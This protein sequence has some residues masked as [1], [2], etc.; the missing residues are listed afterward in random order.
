MLTRLPDPF[1]TLLKPRRI[2]RLVGLCA[3]FA[4]ALSCALCTTAIGQDS[5]DDEVPKLEL[6]DLE[7]DGL[8][9]TARVIISSV[10]DSNP[11]TANDLVRAIS[12]ML[13][14][15]MYNDAKFY[16]ERIN[17]LNLN[18]D[19]MFAL[20]DTVGSDFFFLI[21][22]TPGVQPEGKAFAK[23]VLTTAR[24]ISTTPAKLDPLIQ[25]LNDADVSTRSAAFRKL[26]LLG[27]PAVARM[28][29][30]FSKPANKPLFPGIR[31]AFQHIGA[32]NQGPLLGGAR[33]ANLQV[34]VE[35][36]RALSHL[37]S[38]EAYDVM[39][40]AYLSPK[41]PQSTRRL[42]LDYLSRAKAADPRFIE[43]RLYDR[44]LEYM[45][46]KRE[47][48][49]ALLGEVIM[50][51]WDNAAGRMLP[52]KVDGATASRVIGSRRANDLF[53]INPDSEENRELYYLSQL[54]A[55]KRLAKSNRSVDVKELTG[56]LGLNSGQ[57]ETLLERSLELELIPAAIA[58]CEILKET[59]D[60]SLL[61]GT[62]SNPRPLVQAI[63]FG[64]RHLQFAAFDAISNIDPKQAYAGSSY[65]VSLAVFMAQS[66]NRGAGLIGHNLTSTAQTYAANMSNAGLFG[67]S[68][69]NS[70]DFFAEA[71]DNPDIEV[72]IVTDTMGRPDYAD[73]I[74][75]LRNDWRTKRV[76]I[77][78]LY[79]DPMR[80]R[81][82]TLRVG[83]DP[84][85]L[86][87]PFATDADHVS[88]HI[89]QLRQKL[90]P[91]QISSFE[92]RK[93]AAAGIRWL[94]K[95]AGDRETY[96]FYNLGTHEPKLVRM[97]YVPGFAKHASVILS[98]LGTP[99]AQRELVNF[100]SQSTAPVDERKKVVEEFAKSVETGGTLLTT[101]EIQL[102]YDRYNASEFEEKETQNVLGSILDVIEAR[103]RAKS[104]N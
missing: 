49:G 81:R 84:K 35:S 12:I 101:R 74:Q 4:V 21:H 26:Q 15:E 27:E 11:S 76:P 6:I 39:M 68:A 16:L 100:A 41:V 96:S 17:E 36:I 1:P 47:V 62:A 61:F 72:M 33:A 103:K 102:Q 64:D 104:T 10:R 87:I 93:H 14:I 59:G 65:M 91:W 54:E 98:S 19:Q 70:R 50:W 97:L 7:T 2:L 30:T 44:A 85:Y 75:Q 57:A 9:D 79:R 34:Q 20:H 42:A 63:L 23:K 18:E 55:A 83:D 48:T 32:E 58:C 5:A 73:L 24:K 82:V 8:D 60:E 37:N 92:R 25:Q 90:D 45:M 28:V 43:K 31:G 52:S 95:I 3:L 13:D 29:E 67:Q 22:A 46:G 86:A 66:D 69:N 56:R 78:L 40:R 38:P 71:T 94:E 53:E 99:Q 88:S 89:R 77:A 80:S 51:N